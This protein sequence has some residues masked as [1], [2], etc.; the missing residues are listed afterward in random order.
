MVVNGRIGP[1]ADGSARVTP[2]YSRQM[3]NSSAADEEIPVHPSFRPGESPLGLGAGQ[4]GGLIGEGLAQHRDLNESRPQQNSRN[5]K[6]S[7]RTI[8][9]TKQETENVSN[10]HSSIRDLRFDEAEEGHEVMVDKHGFQ[11]V[12]IQGSESL[13]DML[14]ERDE[15]RDKR[16]RSKNHGPHR[17]PNQT[18]S[19]GFTRSKP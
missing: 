18:C 7:M 3:T 13:E 19:S 2:S 15:S 14:R 12:E 11:L 16:L 8:L 4:N 9:E 6:K 1:P 10:Q 17:I 5:T